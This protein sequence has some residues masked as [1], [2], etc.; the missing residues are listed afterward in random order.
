M[1]EDLERLSRIPDEIRNFRVVVFAGERV[2]VNRPPPP[3]FFQVQDKFAEFHL[4]GKIALPR[5][6]LSEIVRN[7]FDGVPHAFLLRGGGDMNRPADPHRRGESAA[8]FPFQG[9]RDDLYGR[10]GSLHRTHN[11]FDDRPVRIG[12]NR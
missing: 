10:H 11:L 3:R 2:D 12:P 6:T 1:L 5:R 7:P 9:L 4:N 8:V